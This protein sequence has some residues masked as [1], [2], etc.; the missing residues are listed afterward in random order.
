MQ[1]G[2]GLGIGWSVKS[3]SFFIKVDSNIKFINLICKFW[4]MGVKAPM[5]GFICGY[6]VYLHEQNPTVL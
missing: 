5:F 2:S 4:Q 3:Y 6:L 1:A